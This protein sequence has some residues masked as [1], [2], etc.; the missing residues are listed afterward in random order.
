MGL[1]KIEKGEPKIW[2]SIYNGKVERS[3]GGQKNY[4]SYVEGTLAGIY[5]KVRT[6]NG[7]K[8]T[9]WFID[10]RGDEGELYSISLPYNS[11][12]FKSIVLALASDEQLS[13]TSIVRIEPY[14]KGNYTNIV[15]WSDGVKLDWVI[16]ELPPVDT[17]QIGGRNYK[18]DSK[19]MELITSYVNQILS[20][21]QS[22]GT[23]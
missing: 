16:R 5:T 22:N 13:P 10:L 21:L 15:V 11:G 1:G 9:K 7:E 12:A 18:D 6:Y 3:E 4:F 23:K 2:L 14:L 20:R 19:R 17:I 8:V